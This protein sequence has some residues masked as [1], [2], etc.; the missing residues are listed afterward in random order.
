MRITSETTFITPILNSHTSATKPTLSPLHIYIHKNESYLH[1][2]YDWNDVI[3]LQCWISVLLDLHILLLVSYLE[4]DSIRYVS[5]MSLLDCICHKKSIISL[6]LVRLIQTL[7][8]MLNFW[9]YLRSLSNTWS[10]L[11]P[12][13]FMQLQFHPQLLNK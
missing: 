12:H 2:S 6:L 1:Y 7:F 13:I 11:A 4:V 9:I 8:L 10:T 3:L 5:Y